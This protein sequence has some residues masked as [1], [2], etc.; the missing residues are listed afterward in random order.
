MVGYVGIP[1]GVERPAEMF[2][3]NK[4]LS[5][6]PPPVRAYI[7][8]LLDDV[9][10]GESPGRVLD[11]ETD[12]DHIADAYAAMDGGGRSDSSA[13][14]PLDAAALGGDGRQQ[15]RGLVIRATE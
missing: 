14:G 15:P 2:F 12:L 13:W 8:E 6:A 3:R 10:G 9:L 1:H 4:G 11:F 5:A 7:P